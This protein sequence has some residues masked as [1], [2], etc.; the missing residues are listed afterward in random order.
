MRMSSSKVTESPVNQRRGLAASQMDAFGRMEDDTAQPV[1]VDDS[2]G[3]V[4]PPSSPA[5]AVAL[6]SRVDVGRPIEVPIEIE[7][8]DDDNNDDDDLDADL[9]RLLSDVEGA[10]TSR[11]QTPSS[12][13]CCGCGGHEVAGNTRVIF[14]RI[15]AR[16]KWGMVGPHWFGPVCVLFLVVWA[17]HYFIGLS[18][19]IGPLTTGTCIVFTL[20]TIYNLCSASFRD[21]GI[22]RDQPETVDLSNWRWCDFC[23]CVQYEYTCF[24]D[25]RFV[26]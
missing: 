3:K 2:K 8:D 16:T 4:T 23:R 5:R 9:E 14:P 18:L 25:E 19:K 11:K 21:P 6:A 22:V 10:T 13:S 26:V 17:S 12:S 7:Q 15:F 24:V 20:V 1:A